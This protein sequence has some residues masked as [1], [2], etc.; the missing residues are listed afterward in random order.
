MYSGCCSKT[1]GLIVE[2]DIAGWAGACARAGAG[3]LT[4]KRSENSKKIKREIIL[5]SSRFE[6]QNATEIF[7]AHYRF[8]SRCICREKSNI[9]LGERKKQLKITT[10][11]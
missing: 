3:V 1:E 10:Q 5:K 9:L 6:V 8:F 4:P 2:T 11:F 7:F